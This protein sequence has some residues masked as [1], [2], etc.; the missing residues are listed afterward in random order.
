M[1]IKSSVVL[2]I[3]A[4]LL[5]ACNKADV[6]D[7]D[8][9]TH[10]GWYEDY[11]GYQLEGDGS[12][13]YYFDCTEESYPLAN[14]PGYLLIV[15]HSWMGKQEETKTTCQYSVQRGNPNTISINRT[16]YDVVK[17]DKYEM[18]L[19]KSGTEFSPGTVGSNFLHFK[20]INT[21]D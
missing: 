20:R 4:V 17:L 13:L 14:A 7:M 8:L 9:L 11:E 5:Y 12:A 10:G 19:Q 2:L 15:S 21:E 6:V 16:A 18:S 3:T 1:H